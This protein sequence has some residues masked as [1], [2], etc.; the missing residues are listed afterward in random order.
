MSCGLRANTGVV[1]ICGGCFQWLH[2]KCGIRL[3]SKIVCSMKCSGAQQPLNV[4]DEPD[5]APASNLELVT[6]ESVDNNRP[7]TVTASF[8]E[9]DPLSTEEP[10]NDIMLPCDH[11]HDEY[12]AGQPL[13]S[14][15]AT[16]AKKRKRFSLNRSVKV[17]QRRMGGVHKKFYIALPCILCKLKFPDGDSLKAHQEECLKR[18]QDNGGRSSKRKNKEK[19]DVEVEVEKEKMCVLCNQTFPE[20]LEPLHYLSCEKIDN[21]EQVV[22]NDKEDVVK[23]YMCDT[24]PRAFTNV[25]GFKNHR[26]VCN[27]RRQSDTSQASRAPVKKKA[28]HDDVVPVFGGMATTFTKCPSCNQWVS[29]RTFSI[30]TCHEEDIV[31]IKE[32]EN[33]EDVEQDQQP[34]PKVNIEEEQ[35]SPVVEKKSGVCKNCKTYKVNLESHKDTCTGKVCTTCKKMVDF[36]KFPLHSVR[37]ISMNTES[38]FC[39]NCKKFKVNL[40]SHK[41]TCKGKV[42]TTCK[43][44]VDYNKFPFHTVRCGN[45]IRFVKMDVKSERLHCKLCGFSSTQKNRYKMDVHVAAR[46]KSHPPVQ[47]AL[48]RVAKA[49]QKDDQKPNEAEKEGAAKLT[50]VAETKQ[51]VQKILVDNT[52]P[53]VAKKNKCEKCL[54]DN[55]S[56]GNHVCGGSRKCP[57]C[58]KVVNQN[59][60]NDHFVLCR[61]IYSMSTM[62]D[63]GFDCRLC[64]K[65][66]SSRLAIGRHIIDKH[67]VELQQRSGSESVKMKETKVV[68]KKK[69]LGFCPCCKRLTEDY[70]SHVK[71]CSLDGKTQCGFCKE[72]SEQEENLV[73]N[74]IKYCQR[75]I[76]YVRVLET[77]LRCRLCSKDFE[78]SRCRVYEH[79]AAEHLEV[80]EAVEEQQSS[81]NTRLNDTEETILEERE[82]NSSTKSPSNTDEDEEEEH[83]EIVLSSDNEGQTEEEPKKNNDG[84]HKKNHRE[85][86]TI[87]KSDSKA[88][89]P[90]RQLF[91]CPKCPKLFGSE[92]NIKMH[93][94][95]MHNIKYV[96]FND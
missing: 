8:Q 3:E 89:D 32:E 96:L 80:V 6:V 30:H 94:L 45:F 24:C 53:S 61:A 93:L 33:T 21:D 70:D 7:E 31:H 79:I 51:R 75:F 12:P 38:G 95:R 68:V 19:V 37:C 36:N 62:A 60:A 78:G 91:L 52:K 1:M 25:T 66:F 83:E 18:Y 44:I 82:A 55:L 74:H 72:W 11:C 26:R 86:V 17:P 77:N 28:K 85:I 90:K 81:S 41:A 16:C 88:Y 84:E 2:F 64:K 20:F 43:N 92:N 22:D 40:E 57:F 73:A 39:K 76:K 10:N 13:M 54:E 71:K 5:Q 46:H 48:A 65:K 14:H 58:K 4:K 50:R 42:C 67:K 69:M 15:M 87:S 27:T 47:A 9:L 56:S 23:T 35:P 29:T 49:M 34:V 59:A 63:S